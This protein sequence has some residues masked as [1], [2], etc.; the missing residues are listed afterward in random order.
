M[1]NQTELTASQEEV[2]QEKASPKQ[3]LQPII[4]P[5][6]FL[7]E[8]AE[9]ASIY[10]S[11]SLRALLRYLLAYAHE[12]LVFKQ[13]DSN[14]ESYRRACVC[15]KRFYDEYSKHI[16]EVIGI[17]HTELTQLKDLIENLV[18]FKTYANHEDEHALQQEEEKRNL[19][20][21]NLKVV[22]QKFDL[23]AIR[24]DIRELKAIHKLTEF[25]NN[26]DLAALYFLSRYL[27]GHLEEEAFFAERN[28][29]LRWYHLVEAP[30][31]QLIQRLKKK[32]TERDDSLFFKELHEQSLYELTREKFRADTLKETVIAGGLQALLNDHKARLIDTCKTILAGEPWEKL[33]SPHH[34]E[35]C[36]WQ[37]S[38]NP[39]I[40][41][42]DRLLAIDTHADELFLVMKSELQELMRKATPSASSFT[43]P[44]TLPIS[45]RETVIT[46]NQ[47]A[48]PPSKPPSNS[49]SFR[50]TSF[51]KR[52]ETSAPPSIFSSIKNA[53]F[54]HRT[55]NF[56]TGLGVGALSVA[57][58]CAAI[59]L[60]HG[61]ILAVLATAIAIKII[62]IALAGAFTMALGFTLGLSVA[63]SFNV[64]A[65]TVEPT[66]E[67][68]AATQ[69]STPAMRG[70]ST[71]KVGTQLQ[72]NSG[73]GH[74]SDHLARV[75]STGGLP[76]VHHAASMLR[77]QS[78]DQIVAETTDAYT[79]SSRLFEHATHSDEKA[80]INFRSFS[81]HSTAPS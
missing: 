23:E 71:G 63:I 1:P 24:R 76:Q 79:S 41:Q 6:K 77:R 62:E 57:A 39:L 59:I 34:A 56:W 17:K 37:L 4:D 28:L 40:R 7:N 69:I 54:K 35:D 46:Y 14:S 20:E 43:P 68:K 80:E 25:E 47:Q 32:I 2:S 11:S 29:C 60:T 31:T 30:H 33:N 9:N 58:L 26:A 42:F 5:V 72:Q 12:I 51:L 16:L 15:L 49:S 73:K 52:N 70:G 67:K 3:V 65:D 81:N 53:F 50:V 66:G 21:T 27:L 13:L 22:L 44:Q 74:S 38:I 36:D 10:Y 55:R 19:I 64:L 48:K 18:F 75:H 61:A 78:S 8:L 45:H